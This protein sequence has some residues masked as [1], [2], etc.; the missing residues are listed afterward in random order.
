M[1]FAFRRTF[2]RTRVNCGPAAVVKGGH[3]DEVQCTL[4]PWSVSSTMV[5]QVGQVVSPMAGYRALSTAA[6]HLGDFRM[7]SARFLFPL[8]QF[9]QFLMS[10]V[11]ASAAAVMAILDEWA[12]PGEPLMSDAIAPGRRNTATNIQVGIVVVV[13]F[14]VQRVRV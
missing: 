14:G 12:L 2:R 11:L 10:A 4:L 5:S 8:L 7:C 3:R 13:R 6:L 9:G 1:G